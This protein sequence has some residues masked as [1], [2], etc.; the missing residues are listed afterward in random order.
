[1]GIIR[2]GDSFKGGCKS[3]SFLTS[4]R[5]MVQNRLYNLTRFIVQL[6]GKLWEKI[7][8]KEVIGD[9]K[10][11]VSRGGEQLALKR[12]EENEMKRTVAIAAAV[13]LVFV[14]TVPV[15][16]ADYYWT[17]TA[18]APIG[19]ASIWFK[20]RRIDP[21][22]WSKDY[23]S[24]TWKHS[25]GATGTLEGS[26]D[27]WS[28]NGDSIRASGTFS[29]GAVGIWEG[30]FVLE[31]TCYGTYSTQ[32][33][34]PPINGT[35]AGFADRSPSPY[36]IIYADIFDGNADLN[37]FA[38]RKRKKG[39][40]VE[41][42][43]LGDIDGVIYDEP[44]GRDTTDVVAIREYIRNEWYNPNWVRPS[45]V[46]LVGDPRG[47][48]SYNGWEAEWA[49]PEHLPTYQFLDLCEKDFR[50]TSDYYFQLMDDDDTAD[51]ALGRWCVNN[52][53]ELNT[54]V[55]KTLKYENPDDAW[56]P[57]R[58]LLVAHWANTIGEPIPDLRDSSEVIRLMFEDWN[59]RGYE[60]FTAYG[61]TPGTIPPGPTNDTIRAYLEGNQETDGIGVLNYIGH[62]AV[63]KWEPWNGL[64]ETFSND[65]VYSLN[66]THHG[67]P[68][69]YQFCCLTGAIAYGD[70]KVLCEAWTLH[71]DGGAAGALGISGNAVYGHDQLSTPK[72]KGI[73]S[74]HFEENLDCGWAII[75]GGID[76][77]K[78]NVDFDNP[79]NPADT[80]K[81]RRVYTTYW[82]G[83]PELDVWRG[84]PND[85]E[86]SPQVVDDTFLITVLRSSDDE[87]VT[88]TPVCMYS[89]GVCHLVANTDANGQAS[90]PWYPDPGT[91][92]FTATNQVGPICIRP[93]TIDY[94]QQTG[95]MASD[96]VEDKETPFWQLEAISPNPVNSSTVISYS[97]ADAVSVDLKVFDVSGRE[98]RTLASGKHV[99]GHYEA[100][101]NGRDS[102]G[103]NCPSGVY[104]V[105]MRSEGFNAN[106]R[107]V[108]IR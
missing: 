95:F 52:D 84:T 64:G 68:V 99:P 20:M 87:P 42:K 56:E 32:T 69:V 63:D 96:I 101:W 43:M 61:E 5:G 26:G 79:N 98:V 108:L 73:F 100:I 78:A 6:V 105:R 65:T 3:S 37:Q 30:L 89:E 34:N 9:L 66:Q 44:T 24:G 21:D 40:D 103:L 25:L 48:G 81:K 62:A 29:G 16:A 70:N 107:L 94:S 31:D 47:V 10:N 35:F 102:K 91:Y 45:H 57:N 12:R 8:R 88:Y 11:L 46:L 74:G 19:T 15:S 106:E 23:F 14:L 54:M 97:V 51:V 38:E 39:F 72:A 41:M 28:T 50:F 82:I 7:K 1:M 18:D 36:L 2:K 75:K 60:V 104:F 27:W 4:A 33:T 71:P 90:F 13:L 17:A 77:Y 58:T 53:Q 80:I 85:A 93:V 76:F 55:T 22:D 86:I 83:D 92:Y 67:Y 59:I 49:D